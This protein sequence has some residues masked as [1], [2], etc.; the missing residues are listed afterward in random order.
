MTDAK[1]SVTKPRYNSGLPMARVP[2]ATL[3]YAEYLELERTSEQ[4][5]EY[6]RG[7]IFAPT[8]EPGNSLRRDRMVALPWH[9]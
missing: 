5:H 3:S 4:K 6:L 2:I 9:P 8:P 1:R 7:E